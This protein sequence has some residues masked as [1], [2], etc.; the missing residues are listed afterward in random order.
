MGNKDG[1]GVAGT[2]FALA[3]AS[4]ALDDVAKVGRA[5]FTERR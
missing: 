5:E 2:Y 3:G 4:V 1:E